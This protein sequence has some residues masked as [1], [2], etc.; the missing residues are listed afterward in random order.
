MYRKSYSPEIRAKISLTLTGRVLTETTKTKIG[1][2]HTGKALSEETKLKISKALTGKV[3]TEATKTKISEANTGKI[4]S[5]E[6]KEKISISKGTTIYVYTSDKSLIHFTFN[7]Y[8]K[9]AQHFNVD[10]NT[11][12]RYIK[13]A[14]LLKNEWILTTSVF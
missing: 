1:E 2:A 3:L 8:R 7:S 4:L 11:I 5:K 9:A 10:K 13:N 12:N 14:K 6:I